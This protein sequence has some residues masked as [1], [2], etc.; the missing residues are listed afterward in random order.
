[1]NYNEM[2]QEEL[3]QEFAYLREC[4]EIYQALLLDA[5]TIGDYEMAASHLDMV[6]WCEA[7][8]WEVIAEF[9]R[10]QMEVK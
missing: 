7:L 4:W 10:R 9:E 2:A 6:D 1:M 5:I 8:G 3:D